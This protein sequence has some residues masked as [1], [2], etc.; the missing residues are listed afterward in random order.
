MKMD[1]VIVELVE[2]ALEHRELELMLLKHFR[3]WKAHVCQCQTED[4]IHRFDWIDEFSKDVRK[5]LLKFKQ[6]GILENC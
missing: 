3:K 4:E 5:E 1:R 2:F 6:Q